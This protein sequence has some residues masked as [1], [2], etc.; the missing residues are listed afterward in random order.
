MHVSEIEE[1][2]Q[3]LK[4]FTDSRFNL[5]SEQQEKTIKTIEELAQL[6]TEEILAA[7]KET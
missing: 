1:E 4:L 5:K 2:V 7:S 3:K 6:K